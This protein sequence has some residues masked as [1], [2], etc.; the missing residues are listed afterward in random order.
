[1]SISTSGMHQK[2]ISL[3]IALRS[4]DE[5]NQRKINF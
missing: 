4:N 5:I 1:M 2:Y 3:N